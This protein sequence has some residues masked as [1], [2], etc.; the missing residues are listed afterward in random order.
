MLGLALACAGPA[1]AAPGAALVEVATEGSWTARE[2]VELHLV[3]SR[4]LTAAGLQLVGPEQVE[5]ALAGHSAASC[6]DDR[7]RIDLARNLG[8]TRLVFAHLRAESG[9]V[10]VTF[11]MFNAEVGERTGS[12]SRFARGEGPAALREAIGQAATSMLK[13]E[14][15][16][17]A[18]RLAVRTRPSGATITVDGRPLGEGDAEL[19]VTAG[20]HLVL[21]ERV[22]FARA[23]LRID[24][25]PGE[26][27][28]LD[29]TL[30]RLKA[31]GPPPGGGGPAVP[32]G[33]GPAA[34]PGRDA[35]RPWRT[36]GYVVLGAGIAAL[37][38]GIGLYAYGCTPEAGA[39]RCPVK[40]SVRTSGRA[41]VGAGAGLVV[42]GVS[43]WAYDLR[44]AKTRARLSLG[45]G[46]A[47]LAFEW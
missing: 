14:L 21:L 45:P 10:T 23:K 43:L 30:V 1:R 11:V 4:A 19:P 29:V 47:A 37:G 16:M 27:A 41:L 28:N 17:P 25:K 46:S 32:A 5:I 12:A 33:P 15:P 8:V 38:T 39:A 26:V 7:C 22:G 24:L 6:R 34:D 20:K 9:G 18:A 13:A 35:A 44:R 3:V 42:V 36:A 2:Q 31:G 40:A